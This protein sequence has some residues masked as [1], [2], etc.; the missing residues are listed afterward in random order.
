MLKMF[1][2]WFVQVLPA[3]LLL[4]HILMIAVA[5]C[6]WSYITPLLTAD[7]PP[8]SFISIELKSDSFQLPSVI[9]ILP[10]VYQKCSC[11]AVVSEFNS[12]T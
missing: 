11:M 4:S 6:M 3:A 8:P 5:Y 9:M 7:A 1:P 2:F 10:L 12:T